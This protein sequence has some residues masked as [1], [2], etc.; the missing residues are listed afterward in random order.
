[1]STENIQITY[2]MDY[3]VDNLRFSEPEEGAIPDS[4]PEIRYKRINLSTVYP[5]G[6]TGPIILPTEKLFSY[7]V[8]ENTSQETGKVTGW[9]FPLVMYDRDASGKYVP[10]TEQK[11]FVD[12]FENIVEKCKDHILEN[13]EEIDQFEL[14]RANL[15]KFASC[16]YYKKEKVKND[17][18]RTVLQVVPNSSPTLYVKL[19][20]SKKKGTFVTKFYE[21]K[22]VSDEEESGTQVEPLDYLGAY[23]NTK[24]AIKI[25]SIFIGSKI[26]LQVKLYEANI[27]KTQS[28]MKRLLARPKAESRVLMQKPNRNSATEEKKSVA[29]MS[30][31]SDV[32][33]DGTG[34]IVGSDIDGD[35]PTPSSATKSS[36][37]KTKVKKVVRKVKKV[38]RKSEEE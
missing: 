31:D 1:M 33:D 5:D 29:P 15:N 4:K 34:S 11:A 26:S 12:C 8:Q 9:S 23:C 22:D 37:K 3:D 21:M 6:T 30:G 18:G 7:G 35:A 2:P 36:D 24:A 13:K 32:D 27:Q 28:G 19:I 10:T 14:V 38:V 16:L 17:K 25:E 20:F